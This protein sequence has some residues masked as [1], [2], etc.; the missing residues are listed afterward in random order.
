MSLW[1]LLKTTTQGT[2]RSPP[3]EP[4]KDLSANTHTSSP[5]PRCFNHGLSP[6]FSKGNSQH[7]LGKNT[8]DPLQAPDSHSSS[9]QGMWRIHHLLWTRHALR[10][11][12]RNRT[13]NPGDTHDR[14]HL[15]PL[16][17]C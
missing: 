10:H 16:S 7:I 13:L 12:S 6:L 11:L 4:N 3:R 15:V 8:E 1:A 9:M 17:E 5:L 2:G 14:E